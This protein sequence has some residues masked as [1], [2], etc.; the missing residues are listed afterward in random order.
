MKHCTM[1]TGGF[2]VVTVQRTTGGHKWRVVDPDRTRTATTVTIMIK[3]SSRNSDYYNKYYARRR[4][5]QPLWSNFGAFGRCT[6][7]ARV[8]LIGLIVEAE[9]PGL[10]S[11][12]PFFSLFYSHGCSSPRFK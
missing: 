6:G 7:V 10:W 4:P 3:A 1:R 11:Q 5:F 9:A 2:R 12:T 8:G